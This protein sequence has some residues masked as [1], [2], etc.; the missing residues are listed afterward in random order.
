MSVLREF[1]WRVVLLAA[2]AG[3]I[4]CVVAN[5]SR[6][7]MG[8][9]VLSYDTAIAETAN[10]QLLLNAVR[11][12]QHYPKSFTQPGE[13]KASPPVS[14]GIESALSLTRIDGLTDYNVKPNL[15]VSGGYSE[16]S[17]KNLN[18]EEY[19]FNL[20]TEIPEQITDI[21]TRNTNWPRQLI[22]LLYV[23]RFDVPES[24]VGWIDSRRKSICQKRSTVS[25]ARRCEKMEE[26]I[27][28]Y[29][30]QCGDNGHFKDVG[31]RV[32]QFRD[33]R[34]MYYNT[35]S[36]YC[37]YNRF[38]IFL[39]EVRLTKPEVC[40]RPK[41]NCI[42]E[43]RRT[44]LD[45]IGYLG[46]LIKAQNYIHNPFVPQVMV[47]TPVG[48]GFK[49]IDVPLFEV[50]VGPPTELASVIVVHEGVTYYVPRPDFG[51]PHEA[52]S[53]QTLDLVLQTVQAAT[54]REDVPKNSP[55]VGVLAVK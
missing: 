32:R 2:T 20:R 22:D 10:Q 53:M 30:D 50:R 25:E 49:I 37:H 27:A 54:R 14:G 33:D 13:V 40:S 28:E 24:I 43:T 55:T 12:S 18:Y 38:R 48:S 23:Q 44:A 21:F 11:A 41:P 34:R 26:L 46:E 42:F 7:Q 29:A 39:E 16:F 51:S 1:K 15:S 9:N 4:S 36:N 35:A 45:M 31:L 17:L 3:V 19:M 52:R 6:V 5:C 47:G 8:Y